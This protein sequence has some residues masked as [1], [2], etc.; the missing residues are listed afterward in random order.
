[1]SWYLPGKIFATALSAVVLSACASPEHPVPPDK[2]TMTVT[3]AL[4]DVHRCSR[5]SPEIQITT[6]PKGTEYYDVRLVE[7]GDDGQELFLGGGTWE[8]DATGSIPEGGLTRHYRGP[9]PQP[10]KTREYAFVV[11]AMSRKNMQPLAVRI[12]RFTQE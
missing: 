4:Q 6:P 5:I 1:M 2:T 8:Q 10:G 3:V 9:C 11:A 12:Y 7:F